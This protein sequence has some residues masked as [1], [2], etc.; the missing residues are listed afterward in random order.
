MDHSS[1]YPTVLIVL[2]SLLAL[3]VFSRYRKSR[4]VLPPS[5][6][7]KLPLIGHMHH[8]ASNPLPHRALRDLAQ[9]HGPAIMHLQL[10]QVQT[11]VVSSAQ[12]AEAILKTH[13]VNF[14]QRPPVHSANILAY[15]CTDIVFAP[16]GDYWR[17]LRRICTI[18]LFSAKM[19]K[20][21]G[22]IR[23]D[24]VSKLVAAVSAASS[25]AAGV[26][27]TA[28]FC[29]L[30]YSIL[31][32]AAFGEVRE[33]SSSSEAFLPLIDEI[34]RVA[35]GFNIADLYPS[36]KFLQVLTGVASK[37]NVLHE[38]ADKVLESIIADHRAR[39]GHA[40]EETAADL[41]DV[42]LKHHEGEGNMGFSL[43]TDNIKAVLVDLF[44]AGTETTA[45][46][47]DWI[48][49][50]LVKNPRVMQKTQSEVR[51]V[52][53]PQGKV[54]EARLHELTY[55]KMVIRESMRLHPPVAVL[56][57]RTGAE[58]CE[59]G[60]YHIPAGSSIMVNAW[61]IGRNPEYW[62]DAETFWPERFLESSV[63]YKGA[64]FQLLPFGA[65]R[66]ICPGMSFALANLEL[67]LARLLYYFDWKLPDGQENECV[68][69][70]ET[71]GATVK[72]KNKLFLIPT[73]ASSPDGN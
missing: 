47:L 30:T 50:E 54:D 46:S 68:D 59:I 67:P 16:Y 55:L 42:L 45:T 62:T 6:P 63:D 43:T 28:M 65:G 41:L 18:E 8:L 38:K 40:E 19:I 57:P 13:D 37:L 5:P 48:M 60:G 9:K 20:S 1:S 64:H 49:S 3:F 12:I 2:A 25:S 36:F 17:Q 73:V 11:I 7:V 52:F 72:R 66:R 51:R 56:L 15:G 71:F 33:S 4:L 29:K 14:A 35:S 22:S 21:F 70:T 34:T 69:M 53:G 10:G 27:L 61:A 44:F 31:S 23:E 24:E 26:D 39:I 58:D 32:R